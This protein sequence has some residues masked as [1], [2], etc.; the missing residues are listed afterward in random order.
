[1][2]QK[3]EEGGAKVTTYMY[4]DANQLTQI[5]CSGTETWTLTFYYDGLGRRVKTEYY[6]GQTTTT[7]KFVY[8]GGAVIRELNASDQV[9]REYVTP[10][11]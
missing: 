8:L 7:R 11:L 3:S 4:N 9:V 10:Q 6:D 5:S 2:T 1:M